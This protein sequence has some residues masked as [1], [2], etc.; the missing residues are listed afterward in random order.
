MFARRDVFLLLTE[1]S[2]RNI[3]ETRKNLINVVYLIVSFIFFLVVCK[4]S[5]FL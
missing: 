2:V 5:F 3:L 1:L 4:F